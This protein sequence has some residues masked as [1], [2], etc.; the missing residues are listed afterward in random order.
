MKT[1]SQRVFLIL[2]FLIK[3]LLKVILIYKKHFS[4]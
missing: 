2:L 3:V 1:R 4:K